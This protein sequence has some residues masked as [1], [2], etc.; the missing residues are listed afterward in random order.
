MSLQD[1]KDRLFGR[2]LFFDVSDAN[3]ADL[4]VA[5]SGDWLTVTGREAL[6]QSVI[7]RLLTSPGEWRTKP[8]Y[9]VG[10]RDFVKTKNTSTAREYLKTRI[11]SQ[12]LKDTRIQE[13]RDVRFDT[14]VASTLR[15][16]V[17]VVP[18]G[19]EDTFVIESPGVV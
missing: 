14:S 2:D 12:L 16:A 4:K 18:K 19:Q 15:I 9:G 11:R 1:Q 17:Y 13:V 6:R 5:P 3:G 7:R 8:D 10:L